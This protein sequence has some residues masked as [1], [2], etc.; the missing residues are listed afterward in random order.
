MT[1]ALRLT[2][3]VTNLGT[4]LTG[5][6]GANIPEVEIRNAATGAVVQAAI[7]GTEIGSGFWGFDFT[8]TPGLRYVARWDHDPAGIGQVTPQERYASAGFAEFFD[9]VVPEGGSDDYGTLVQ[10]LD[11]AVSSRASQADILSDGTPFPGA[12]IDADVSSRASQVSVDGLND[13]SQAEILSDATPFPGGSIDAAISSRAVAGDAMALTGAAVDAIWDEPVA[14]HESAGTVGKALT[15]LFLEHTRT[16]L[17]FASGAITGGGR[18]VPDGAISHM[19]VQ[20]RDQGGAFPGSS[21]FVVF[22]YEAS[23][24]ASTPPRT[25]T[26]QAA[27]PVDG[28]FTSTG[29][30]S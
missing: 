25:S 29:F 16:L 28:S 8:P 12:R 3:F 24:S 20:V 10:R 26:T 9:D 23:D 5:L 22:N 30:P 19:E 15:R 14:G 7:D 2:T 4:P 11:A 13:L 1:V 6:A 21:Y 18:E 17:F 27:A